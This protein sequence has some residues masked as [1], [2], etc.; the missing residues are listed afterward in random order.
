MT[1]HDYDMKELSELIKGSIISILIMVAIHYKWEAV[2]PLVTQSILG[3]YRLIGNNLFKSH[4]IGQD[5]KRPFPK[6]PGLFS[7]K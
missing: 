2:V 1:I 4:V 3:P 5:I 7:P 6:P